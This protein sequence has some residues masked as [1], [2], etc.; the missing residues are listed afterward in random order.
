[1]T[2]SGQM[3]CSEQQESLERQRILWQLPEGVLPPDHAWGSPAA[4]G[5]QSCM[6]SPEHPL[7]PSWAGKLLVCCSAREKD[8][9]EPP[10][11]AAQQKC[12]VLLTLL[13]LTALSSRL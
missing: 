5:A 3:H 13:F 6:Q 9:L 8:V 12:I 4:C 10:R 1:M 7:Q 11:H 2:F